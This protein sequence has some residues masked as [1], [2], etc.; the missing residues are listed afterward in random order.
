MTKNGAE[1][2]AFTRYAR[3]RLWFEVVDPGSIPGISTIGA[4]WIFFSVLCWPVGV[5]GLSTQPRHAVTCRAN[6]A[7][8]RFLPSQ[9]CV[10]TSGK[11]SYKTIPC[12]YGV[13]G[14]HC[15][16]LD[17]E[18]DTFMARNCSFSPSLTIRLHSSCLNQAAKR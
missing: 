14:L 18:H 12:A 13:Q 11:K 9:V 3:R 16:C 8:N 10:K 7:S 5:K 17:A 15:W 1:Q 4:L 2:N 6:S